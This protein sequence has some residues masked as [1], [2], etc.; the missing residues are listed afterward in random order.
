M[1]EAPPGSAEV[2]A[3]FAANPHALADGARSVRRAI[4]S[5]DARVTESVKWQAPSFTWNTIDFA[6]FSMRRPDQ[7]QVIL[8]TGAKERLDIAEI[9]VESVG[10]RSRRAGRNREIITFASNA[11]V[12]AALESFDRAVRAWIQALP[13]LG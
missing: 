8:H 3:W 11:E 4:L 12:E 9:S 5:A 10:R 2:E 6:T 1:R 13:V 7:L